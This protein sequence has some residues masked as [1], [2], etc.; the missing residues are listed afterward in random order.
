MISGRSAWQVGGGLKQHPQPTQRPQGAPVVAQNGYTRIAPTVGLRALALGWNSNGAW[1][2]RTFPTL[3]GASI[4]ALR[5][6]ND[7]F[8]GCMLSDAVVD[9][10]AFG[11]L[12]VAQATDD[13]SRLFAATG[14]TPELARASVDTQVT[15]G[16]REQPRSYHGCKDTGLARIADSAGIRGQ[17]VYMNCNS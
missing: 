17:V 7:Q 10:T 12:V 2:V 8:G 11:C 4:D 14:G 6:C 16:P 15:N 9:P 13:A 3:A 1:V 5:T